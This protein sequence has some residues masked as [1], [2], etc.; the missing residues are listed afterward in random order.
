VTAIQ[1]MRKEVAITQQPPPTEEELKRAK[2]A[3]LNSFVFRYDSKDKLL[4]ERVTLEFYGY[5]ADF[6]EKY[7]TGVER[8]TLADVQRVG[9]KYIHPEQLATV[10]VGKHE[11]FDKPLTTLGQVKELDISIPPPSNAAKQP[12]PGQQP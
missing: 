8:V 9:A 5:P 11:A 7:R 12:A 3:I 4:S 1:A 10:V 6:V 2:D